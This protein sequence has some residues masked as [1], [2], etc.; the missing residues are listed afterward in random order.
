VAPVYT[1]I[2]DKDVKGLIIHNEISG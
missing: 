1:R 2:A